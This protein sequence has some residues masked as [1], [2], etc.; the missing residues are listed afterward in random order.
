MFSFSLESQL[1]ALALCTFWPPAGVLLWFNSVLSL[2]WLL[3]TICAVIM[4]PSCSRGEGLHCVRCCTN[5]QLKDNSYLQPCNWAAPKLSAGTQRGKHQQQVGLRAWLFFPFPNC[6]ISSN[7]LSPSHLT[8][9]LLYRK[10]S[11][12][13]VKGDGK[14]FLSSTSFLLWHLVFKQI[15]CICLLHVPLGTQEENAGKPE[16]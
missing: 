16:N 14:S 3:F 12:K 1:P 7:W 6:A 15:I 10:P 8:C 2:T 4:F 5:T 13:T 11:W 9:A